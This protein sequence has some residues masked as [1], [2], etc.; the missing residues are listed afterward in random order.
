MYTCKICKKEFST[1][2]RKDNGTKKKKPVPDFC[3]KNCAN[4]RT[5]SESS[6]RNISLGLKEY[7]KKNPKLKKLHKLQC[8]VCGNVF[9]HKNK[10]IKTCCI[11]CKNYLLSIIRSQKLLLNGTDNFKTKQESFTYKH[12]KNI[13]CDSKLE[14]AGII[15]LVDIVKADEIENF[16]NILNFWEGEAHRTYNPDFYVRKNNKR[17][18]CEVKMPWSKQSDHIYNRTIPLKKQVLKKYCDEKGFEMMWLDYDYDP[19]FKQIYNR[20]I[21]NKD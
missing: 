12:I 4:T 6:K 16:N 9:E 14:M 13:M 19:R 21:K 1:D 18:I 7:F 20:L 2:W 3:S 8:S 15:Y 5:R 11:S 10:T 17:I